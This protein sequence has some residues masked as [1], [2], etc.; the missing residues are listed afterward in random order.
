MP[1]SKKQTEWTPQ[2]AKTGE[3]SSRFAPMAFL[4]ECWRS[5]MRHRLDNTGLTKSKIIFSNF[6]LHIQPVKVHRR[7]LKLA[8]TCGLGLISLYLFF[9]LVVS[10]ILIMFHYVPSITES[11]DGL[12]EAYSRMLNLRS[13][14]F[15]GSFIRNLHRWSA[16]AM[17]AVVFLH[18]LRVFLTGAYKAPRQFNWVIG[19]ILALLTLF[20]SYTG[21]LLPWDQLAYWGVKV[22]TEIARI[23]PGGALIRALLLGDNEVGAEALLRFYVLH[24]GLL[25]L[26]LSIGIGLHLW[27]VRKDGGLARPECTTGET[28]IPLAECGFA[29]NNSV[30]NNARSYQLVE[31][32]QGTE[33]K[34]DEEVEQMVF[35]WPKLIVRELILFVFTLALMCIISVCFDAGL[36][37]PANPAIPT[38]PAKAPWYFL[39]LQE[40]VSYHA[41]IG[42]VAIPGLLAGLVLLYPYIEMFVERLF[43]IKDR[44]G[45]GVWFARQRWLENLF[46]ISIFAIMGLLI[47]VGTYFRGPNWEF[48]T[49]FQQTEI[50]QGGH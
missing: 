37:G 19:C 32:V 43:G 27:R 6:F 28:E 1:P 24:V 30:Y 39:G 42:G 7:S 41:F 12:P 16:H 2:T 11:P 44:G 20:L 45:Q 18:M 38:N 34:V 10:G 36:E 47:I 46:M 29:K 5:L 40:L 33:P 50:H 13:N 3:S 49:P 22:G 35:S 21:Y 25:P 26:V 4:Y 17:V 23:A 15:W 31:L 14:V 48:I 9:I 8:T